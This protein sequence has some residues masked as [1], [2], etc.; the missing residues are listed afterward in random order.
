MTV[1]A[2]VAAVTASAPDWL[3]AALNSYEPPPSRF[4]NHTKKK[5]Q[6]QIGRA[7]CSV[8]VFVI[9]C[10]ATRAGND[11]SNSRLEAANSR[12][13]FHSKLVSLLSAFDRVNQWRQRE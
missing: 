12:A 11:L 6:N 7:F 13:L 2:K 10:P 8:T 9:V 1:A 4:L 3:P 5:E